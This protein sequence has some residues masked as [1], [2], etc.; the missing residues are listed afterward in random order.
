M[1]GQ[2]AEGLWG[3]AQLGGQGV[4]LETTVTQEEY[5][6]EARADAGLPRR[7]HR[8]PPAALIEGD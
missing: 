1:A 3:V 8:L 4:T 5:K 6:Y 2:P 7:L